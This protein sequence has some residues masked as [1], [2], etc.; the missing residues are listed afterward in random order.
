M[1]LLPRDQ[2]LGAMTNLGIFSYCGNNSGDPLVRSYRL[3][4]AE[5]QLITRLVDNKL[6]LTELGLPR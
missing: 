3:V 1:S 5:L 2:A 6:E 4:V